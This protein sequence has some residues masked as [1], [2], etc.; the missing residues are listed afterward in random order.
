VWDNQ[1]RRI[2]WRGFLRHTNH[3]VQS[4][5]WEMMVGGLG[6]MLDTM[7]P[8]FEQWLQVCVAAT[9]A[10]VVLFPL[11]PVTLPSQAHTVSRTHE[12]CHA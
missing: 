10:L 2:A 4:A 1:S 11:P 9:T 3:R 6:A 7:W 5:L 8:G 12:L